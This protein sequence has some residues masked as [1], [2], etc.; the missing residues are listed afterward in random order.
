MHM[1]RLAD[2][3]KMP[4]SYSLSALSEGLSQQIM[5]VKDMM[6]QHW[7]EQ[8]TTGSSTNGNNEQRLKTLLLYE[9]TTD[10]IKKVNIKETFGFHK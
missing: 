4:G 7:K 2:P 1:A 6:I 10:K 8:Y 9:A 3:S 5:E